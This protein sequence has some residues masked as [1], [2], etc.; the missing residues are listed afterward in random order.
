M[1]RQSDNALEPPVNASVDE[2]SQKSVDNLDLLPEMKRA[3][4]YGYEVAEA[5]DCDAATFSRW[6]NGTGPLPS[7]QGRRSVRAAIKAIAKRK[8]E[9]AVA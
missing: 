2:S 3:G 1:S 7:G 9:E 5:L 8:A 4:V 6:V